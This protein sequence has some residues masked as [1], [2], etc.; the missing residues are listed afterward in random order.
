MDMLLK[1][2]WPGNVRE[3][4]NAFE[5]A[6][7]LMTGDHITENQLPPSIVQSCPDQQVLTI[8]KPLAIYLRVM[9]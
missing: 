1:Y 7:V 8:S 5:R 4:E 9:A 3:L 2:H 6:V